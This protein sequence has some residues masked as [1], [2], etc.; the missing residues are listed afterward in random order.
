MTDLPA[1]I[2]THIAPWPAPA[3]K[4]FLTLHRTCCAVALANEVGRLHIALKWGQPAWRPARPRTGSTLRASWS[5]DAPGHLAT[6]VDCKTDLA[7]QMALRFPQQ[8]DN[9]GTRALAFALDGPLP[10]AALWQLAQLTLTYHRRK[11]AA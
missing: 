11:R 9:D 10:D 3:R 8:F 6:F 5:P 2:A 1:A 7:A 4:A